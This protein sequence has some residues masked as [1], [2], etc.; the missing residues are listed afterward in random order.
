MPRVGSPTAPRLLRL[1][2]DE[3]LLDRIAPEAP[4]DAGRLQLRSRENV[5]VGEAVRVEI[6]FGPLADEVTLA[7]VVARVEPNEHGGPDTVELRIVADHGERVAYIREVLGGQ[8]EASARKH[9]RVPTDLPVRWRVDDRRNPSSTRWA[10]LGSGEHAQAGPGGNPGR[11]GAEL[12]SLTKGAPAGSDA[13]AAV[14]AEAGAPAPTRPATSSRLGDLSRGGAFVISRDLPEIGA[15][16]ELEIPG[17]SGAA[18]RISSVVS[19]VRRKGSLA[20]FGVNFKFDDRDTA[21]ELSE[22]VR[23]QEAGTLALVAAPAGATTLGAW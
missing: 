5:L 16:V 14:A 7:C 10:S 13:S 23:A 6:S 17:L 9:R 4:G 1:R 12:G 11:R 15:R 21:A 19:W 20:G 22:V 18:L 3:Q 8:R 2:A